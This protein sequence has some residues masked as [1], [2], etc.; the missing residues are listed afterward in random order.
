M[1]EQSGPG[2]ANL[3]G[4]P[5]HVVG[6]VWSAVLAEESVD[7]DVGFFDLGATSANILAAVDMLRRRWPDLRVVE[8]YLYPTVNTLAAFLDDSSRR[9]P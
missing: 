9:D 6:A 2:P 7:P 3:E 4:T 5:R 8:I 1:T